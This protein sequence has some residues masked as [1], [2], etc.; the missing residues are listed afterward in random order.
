MVWNWLKGSVCQCN[1][2]LCSCPCPTA[3]APPEEREEGRCS[4]PPPLSLPAASNTSQ[5]IGCC[6]GGWGSPASA[7]N[8]LG[9]IIVWIT[10][11]C[12]HPR[13]CSGQGHLSPG[14]WGHVDLEPHADPQHQPRL[15]VWDPDT[16]GVGWGPCSA[17]LPAAPL[18]VTN[19]AASRRKPGGG[20][21]GA[22]AVCFPFL[23]LGRTGYF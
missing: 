19:T 23:A 15:L 16:V 4:A 10:L 22:E 17:A 5:Q 8:P 6:W 7:K 20:S 9:N 12:G 13:P 11:Q 21:S 2:S 14:H 18:V 3:Q 1:T